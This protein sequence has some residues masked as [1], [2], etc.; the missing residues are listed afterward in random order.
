MCYTCQ[1]EYFRLRIERPGLATAGV[2]TARIFAD[3]HSMHGAAL[4]RMAAGDIRDAAEKAWCATVRATEGVVLART[5]E[6]PQTSTA[7]GRRLRDLAHT[8]SSFLGLRRRYFDAQA[9]LHGECFY[10]DYC[11]PLVTEQMIQETAEYI[12]EAQELASVS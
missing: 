10:H 12:R 5:G 6:A 8:D 3:A 4:E 2:D 11:Q 7:A 9:L 1:A